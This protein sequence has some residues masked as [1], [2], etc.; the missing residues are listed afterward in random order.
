[1]YKVQLVYKVLLDFRD[2]RESR[3]LQV[4]KDLKVL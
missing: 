3:V 2:D 1:V 4:L